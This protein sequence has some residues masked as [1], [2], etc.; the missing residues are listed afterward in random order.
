MATIIQEDKGRRKNSREFL[1]LLCDRTASP[2]SFTADYR[3]YMNIDDV[4]DPDRLATI[5][6]IDDGFL[7]DRERKVLSFLEGNKRRRP[8]TSYS[9]F[10]WKVVAFLSVQDI[11]DAPLVLGSDLRSLFRQWYFYYEAKF[12]L[13]ETILCGLNGSWGRPYCS[14]FAGYSAAVYHYQAKWLNAFWPATVRSG[15]ECIGYSNKE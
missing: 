12:L 1:Q 10:K 3:Y 7:S 15:S 4:S 5:L 13:V 9:E 11:F 6:G 14:P 2:A 8:D